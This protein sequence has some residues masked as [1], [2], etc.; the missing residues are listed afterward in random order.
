MDKERHGTE[1]AMDTEFFLGITWADMARKRQGLGMPWA[2]TTCQPGKNGMSLLGMERP[3][4][5][6]R[7]GMARCGT[8]MSLKQQ[9]RCMSI[10]KKRHGKGIRARQVMS[11]KRA[12]ATHANVGI[13][14]K[15]LA[16]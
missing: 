15:A 16:Q 1:T 12:K 14:S 5:A 9:I 4:L 6:E 2:D 8:R 7:Q 13:L 10:G 3:V 11:R